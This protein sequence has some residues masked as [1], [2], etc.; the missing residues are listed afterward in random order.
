MN[1]AKSSKAAKVIQSA[2]EIKKHVSK[3]VVFG[4]AVET[5][6]FLN[7]HAALLASKS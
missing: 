5:I 4:Q 6:S 3:R 1:Q 2:K 7:L